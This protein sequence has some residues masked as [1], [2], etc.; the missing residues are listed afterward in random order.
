MA[1]ALCSMNIILLLCDASM[2]CKTE[3]KDSI[4][5][6]RPKLGDLR[7]LYRHILPQQKKPDCP[8]IASI[9]KSSVNVF[10]KKALSFLLSVADSPRSSRDLVAVLQYLAYCLQLEGLSTVGRSRATPT[11]TSHRG[12]LAK[13]P[14]ELRGAALPQWLVQWTLD[15][16]AVDTGATKAPQF[17][18]WQTTANP[19]SCLLY[20]Y[21]SWQDLGQQHP[22]V[23]RS[24]S[25]YPVRSFQ[26]PVCRGR[27]AGMVRDHGWRFFWFQNFR[28]C[29][30]WA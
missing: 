19:K 17:S 18:K 5:V 7:Q 21:S 29:D 26:C 25:S 30:F 20:M 12:L 4:L 6:V 13:S 27:V 11:H 24:T 8:T 16:M 23:P 3:Q 9:T 10:Q 22:D 28:A 15:E 1:C 2:K 14:E